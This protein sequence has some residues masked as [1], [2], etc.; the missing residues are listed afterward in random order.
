MECT[1]TENSS[2]VILRS[3]IHRWIWSRE[4]MHLA[5]RSTTWHWHSYHIPH[6]YPMWQ[7]CSNY[8]FRGP[9]PPCPRQTHIKYHFLREQVQSRNLVLTYGNTKDNVVDVLTKPLDT[10]L[11]NVYVA[12]QALVKLQ[13]IPCE[14]EKYHV[15]E[16]CWILH[17]DTVEYFGRHTLF[18][19]P[20]LWR[21]W[22]ILST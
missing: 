15:G 4:S 18:N 9:P 5:T 11:S 17:H 20:D 12:S 10:R 8:P 21:L 1:Q 22:F 3:Q 13:D 7:Q 2:C 6:Y 16:E 14:E 19:R